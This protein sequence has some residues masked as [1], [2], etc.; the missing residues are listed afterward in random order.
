MR[1][2]EDCWPHQRLT[3]A[4]SEAWAE[5]I[6]HL[7]YGELK[8]AL[9]KATTNARFRPDPYAVLEAARAVRRAESLHHDPADTHPD[10]PPPEADFDLARRQVASLRTLIRRNPP[11]EED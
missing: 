5:V 3:S 1:Y 4:Q 10:G 7:H 8:P 6:G 9:A 11:T 2:V